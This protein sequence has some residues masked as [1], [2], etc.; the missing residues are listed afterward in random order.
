[1]IISLFNAIFINADTNRPE[2][3]EEIS[4]EEAEWSD[5]GDPIYPMDFDVDFG[6]DW[7]YPVKEF[8]YFS[9]ELKPLNYFTQRTLPDDVIDLGVVEDKMTAL[10][11][12][13]AQQ[14][15]SDWVELIEE[16]TI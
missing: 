11:A 2:D 9:A 1:M 15:N 3:I 16:V 5:E 7:D 14:P 4:D 10:A 12:L 6:E 8:D 13:N